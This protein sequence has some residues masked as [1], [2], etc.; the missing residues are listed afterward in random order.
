MSRLESPW[1]RK[2]TITSPVPSILSF[3][4]YTPAQVHALA[5]A[6][7][8]ACVQVNQVSRVIGYERTCETFGHVRINVYHTT[9]TVGTVLK[10]PARDQKTQLF[11]RNVDTLRALEEIFVNPRVHTDG[12]YYRKEGT[13]KRTRTTMTRPRRMPVSPEEM[14]AFDPVGYEQVVDLVRDGGDQAR[15]YYIL[16]CM[17]TYSDDQVDKVLGAVQAMYDLRNKVS[18]KSFWGAI[19]LWAQRNSLAVKVNNRVWKSPFPDPFDPMTGERNQV[20]ECCKYYSRADID[21]ALSQVYALEPMLQ[22]ELMSFYA[23][24]CYVQGVFVD[25]DN[26]GSV[27]PNDDAFI[28]ASNMFGLKFVTTYNYPES[29]PCHGDADPD[30]DVDE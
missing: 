26:D 9:G 11:R 27:M 20:C 15:F 4:P 24:K 28:D 18:F 19:F 3:M 25:K 8:Y 16:R 17:G 5:R 13:A 14:S 2:L 29:C 12:G 30:F 22:F 1:N 7:A 21:D 10:H 23:G 6:H